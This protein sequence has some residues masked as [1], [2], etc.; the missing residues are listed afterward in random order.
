MFLLTTLLF[1]L[2]LTSPSLI[3]AHPLDLNTTALLT[4]PFGP[5]GGGS[6]ANPGSVYMCNGADWTGECTYL[7]NPLIGDEGGPPCIPIA[8]EWQHS[9]MSIGGDEGP[10]CLSWQ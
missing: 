5:P 9:I 6:N 8:A 7:R 1:P 2:L 3:H 10:E 4:A